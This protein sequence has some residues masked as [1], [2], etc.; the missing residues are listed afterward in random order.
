MGHRLRN[1]TFLILIAILFSCFGCEDIYLTGMFKSE[2]TVNQRFE[3]SVDWNQQHAFRE[4]TVP[5]DDYT[6]L[7][8]G[9]SHVGGT[10]NID[11]FF[12]NAIDLNAA[13]VVMVGDLTTGHEEDYVLLQQHIPEQQVLPSFQITGN[14]DLYFGGWNYFYSIFGSSTYYFSVKTPEASDLFICLDSGGGTLGSDQLEWLKDVLVNDRSNFRR[15]VVLTHCNFFRF[16]HTASTNP[17][18]EELQ[19]LIELFTRYE[20][21]MLIT[22]HDHMK[23]DDVFGNTTYIVM[24]AL[25]DGFINAG[26]FQLMIENG[27]I[28]YQ[29]VNL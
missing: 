5:S 9:D 16:R 13:A 29:F 24:D 1:S 2:Q 10:E 23:S 3:Q 11:I 4:I 20:V 21:D 17:L 27:T 26:F 28:D 12:N 19:V 15:C 8:M 25:L 14:H 6:I 18:V 22:G 7:T